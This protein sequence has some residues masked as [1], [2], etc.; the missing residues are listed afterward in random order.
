MPD[1][2][3][4]GQLRAFYLKDEIGRLGMKAA[5]ISTGVPQRPVYDEM[6]LTLPTEVETA[7]AELTR[8]DVDEAIAEVAQSRGE[9]VSRTWERVMKLSGGER[10]VMSLT[11]AI[12]ELVRHPDGDGT[13]E[14]AADLN[15][16][17]R[18]A[19]A[20]KGQALQDGSYPIPDKSHLR[21]AAILAASGH[22]NV[23]AA[24]R[25]IRKRA[26]ELGVD[27]TTLPGFSGE[28]EAADAKKTAATNAAMDALQLTVA[29]VADYVNGD[30]YQVQ[31][32]ELAA[33]TAAMSP[34]EEKTDQIIKAHPE[35]FKKG[36]EDDAPR[37]LKTLLHAPDD[38]FTGVQHP[39]RGPVTTA[40]RAH[41]GASGF[42]G[43]DDILSR[44]PQYDGRDKAASPNKSWGPSKY[45]SP[46][47]QGR[48]QT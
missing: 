27:I 43:A 13:I 44:H 40:T 5:S 32:V 6:Q 21:A 29:D 18:H 48:P 15:M 12:S 7:T 20:A 2:T 17:Q 39:R 8:D 19:L 45:V 10:D 41:T 47:Y 36:D 37:R 38:E 46:G 3:E 30:P 1:Y 35:L 9:D 24:K 23:A 28:S 42:G 25:L 34:E 33:R 4:D 31:R 26:R 22:G 11:M 14:L 16:D